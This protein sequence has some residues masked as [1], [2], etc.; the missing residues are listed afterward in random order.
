MMASE[1]SQRAAA[2]WWRRKIVN[3]IKATEN[4]NDDNDA[5]SGK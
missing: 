2:A 3:E 4:V 1:F 5:M